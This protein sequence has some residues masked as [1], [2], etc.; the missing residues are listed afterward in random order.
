MSYIYE[1]PNATT[2]DGVLVGLATAVP[3]LPTMILMFVWFFVFIGGISKQN[4]KLGYADVPQWALLASLSIF[5][6]SL[7][8]SITAGMVSTFTLSIVTA[9]TILSAV[10]FFLSKGRI[11]Q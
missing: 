2:P 10:W 7:V 9:I 4:A 11:E 1:F 8:M 5:M 6:M 3:I